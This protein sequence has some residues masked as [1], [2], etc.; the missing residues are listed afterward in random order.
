MLCCAL[1]PLSPWVT[2][3]MHSYCYGG[4]WQRVNKKQENVWK[5]GI[6]IEN[7]AHDFPKNTS[8]L[9]SWRCLCFLMQDL[10]RKSDQKLHMHDFSNLISRTL[11]IIRHDSQCFFW[12]KMS[13]SIL[14][15]ISQEERNIK[16]FQLRTVEI[17]YCHIDGSAAQW[18][19][20]WTQHVNRS[21][22]AM[23]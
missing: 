15:F 5:H 17:V 3:L 12:T 9:N 16:H 18:H 2:G 22:H 13:N 8:H 21:S 14:N 11:L 23:I 1:P 4:G 7:I 20:P 19:G 10:F 6:S